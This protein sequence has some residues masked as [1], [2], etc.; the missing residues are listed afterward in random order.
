M[1]FD[2]YKRDNIIMYKG[3]FSTSFMFYSIENLDDVRE[4]IDLRH[5]KTEKIIRELSENEDD[6]DVTNNKLIRILYEI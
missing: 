5:L 4:T 3:F 6:V 2:E 1:K